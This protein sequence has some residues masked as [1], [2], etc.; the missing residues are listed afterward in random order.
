MGLY[1]WVKPK[2][3]PEGKGV[4]KEKEAPI[5]VYFGVIQRKWGRMIALGATQFVAS[6]PVLAFAVFALFGMYAFHTRPVD[7]AIVYG[8]MLQFM[9]ICIP[10]IALISGPA[11]MGITYVLR[12]YAREQHS[13]GFS[14]MLEKA[15][16][17]YKQG[18]WVGLINSVFMLFMVWM[19]YYYGSMN[20]EMKLTI[21]NYIILVLM[22]LF[23]MMRSYLYP[24]AVSYQ[25]SLKDL[26]RYS[27]A[28]V[29]IKLPQNL[30]LQLA[31]AAVIALAF[32]IYP[33]I[34][35]FLTAFGGMAFVGYTHIFYIDRV[36]LQ[37]MDEENE[38]D[39]ELLKEK[40]KKTKKKGKKA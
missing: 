17:N 30:L 21:V 31:S 16:K 34:G 7:G 10:L 26:Y 33:T 29:F 40:Q 25:V 9:L 11:T 15:S 24:M 23:L 5:K 12:N 2:P 1:S 39:Y 32:A 19:Y 38:K 37:N 27:M 14:D 18:F 13:W 35:I 22:G 20:G 36:L 6:L 28:L 3:M 8:N 4:S